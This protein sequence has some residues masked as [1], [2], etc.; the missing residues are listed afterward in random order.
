MLWTGTDLLRA[1]TE[2]APDLFSVKMADK[3]QRRK[4]E[5]IYYGGRAMS[6]HHH[7][8]H[9]PFSP[10]HESKAENE[11]RDTT[12]AEETKEQ[13]TIKNTAREAAGNS[14]E[15][16]DGTRAEDS[17]KA[18]SASSVAESSAAPEGNQESGKS[19][20]KD[21]SPEEQ[22][23]QLK[24]ALKVAQAEV[25][26]VRMRAQAET[27][28][29]KKRLQREHEEHLKYAAEKVLKDLI[30]TLDNLELAITYGSDNEACQDMLKGITMTHKLFIDALGRHGLLPVGKEGELFDPARHE[31][32]GFDSRADLKP[33]TVARVLQSGYQLEGR[34]LRPAKVMVNRV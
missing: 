22:I 11:Q 16:S 4:A 5:F 1:L 19:S 34:L 32:V 21:A 2:A 13:E 26:D 28:N 7:H 8:R 24:A 18:Q 9:N 25:L 15:S 17:A 29:F 23:A 33:D 20:N 3:P 27:E 31:A 30:P 12:M 14:K 10:D 6:R